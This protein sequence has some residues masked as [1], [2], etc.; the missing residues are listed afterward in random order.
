MTEINTCA[1]KVI[2]FNKLIDIIKTLE[3]MSPYEICEV[4]SKEKVGGYALA[5]YGFKLL[6]EKL[7]R[8]EKLQEIKTATPAPPDPNYCHSF[9][10]DDLCRHCGVN[11]MWSWRDC[12]APKKD[13]QSCIEE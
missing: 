1:V 13:R 12:I 9:S 11:I 3:S 8:D 2:E 5:I 6:I 7:F 10:H 4:Y